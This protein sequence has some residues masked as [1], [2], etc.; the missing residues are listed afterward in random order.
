M[1]EIQI[2][3][4]NKRIALLNNMTLFSSYSAI[5][6]QVFKCLLGEVIGGRKS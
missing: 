1:I 3:I 5:F 6:W 2:V 4:L